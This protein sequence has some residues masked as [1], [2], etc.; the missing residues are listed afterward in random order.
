M[1]WWQKPVTKNTIGQMMKFWL[2]VSLISSTRRR[3]YNHSAY[4]NMYTRKIPVYITNQHVQKYSESLVTAVAA[5]M[6]ENYID[7]HRNVW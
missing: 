3:L 4:S 1:L 6:N 7:W 5:K 2:K